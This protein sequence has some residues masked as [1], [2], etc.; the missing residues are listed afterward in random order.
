MSDEDISP[1]AY[2]SSRPCALVLARHLLL[3]QGI[4]PTRRKEKD[5]M[6]EVWT[7]LPL[8]VKTL[9]IRKAREYNDSY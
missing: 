5:M 6:V 9:W 1:F 7:A 8:D 2:F 3:S 4:A